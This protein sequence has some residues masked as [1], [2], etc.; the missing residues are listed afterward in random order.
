MRLTTVFNTNDKNR[1]ALF[2]ERGRVTSGDFL[3]VNYEMQA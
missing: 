2:H 3:H 1:S